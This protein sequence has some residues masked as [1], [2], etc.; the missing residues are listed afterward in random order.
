MAPRTDIAAASC[1]PRLPAAAAGFASQAIPIYLTEVAPARLR[2]GVTV[3]NA[4][5]MVLG[6]LVAQLMNYG[7]AGEALG[8]TGRHRRGGC[9]A[10][11]AL[12]CRPQHRSRARSIRLLLAGVAAR[13]P[14]T[15]ARRRA[16]FLPLAPAAGGAAGGPACRRLPACL[17]PTCP[18]LRAAALR[19][20]PESWRLTLGLP[21]G[22][23]LVICLTIPFLPESPNSLI[24]R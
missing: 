19:D 21:A 13:Q 4:L 11:T 15:P 17:P 10:G 23:A 9:S 5:A 8:G 7:A 24:Q 6:I 1:L 3:M 14:A 22:P 16:A 20:W 12:S 18:C 2:G